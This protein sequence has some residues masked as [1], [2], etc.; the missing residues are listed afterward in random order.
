[1]FG[2]NA[3]RRLD[4]FAQAAIHLGEYRKSHHGPI[5]E[6]IF[7]VHPGGCAPQVVV[8]WK[9]QNLRYFETTAS[10]GLQHWNCCIAKANISAVLQ[11]IT[12]SGHQVRASPVRL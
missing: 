6:F 12:H 8:V 3:S 9:S 4:G 1:L 10:A 11:G 2:L 7:F 5:E